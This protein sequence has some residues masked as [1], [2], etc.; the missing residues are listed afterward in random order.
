MPSKKLL[1]KEARRRAEVFKNLDKYLRIIAE[2]VKKLDPEAKAYLIGSV[3]EGR[4]LLSSDIDV[5]IVTK[6][7]PGKILSELWRAG[8]KDPFEI[9]V[10]PKNQLKKYS[11]KTK[12]FEI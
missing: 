11:E 6:L 2:V 8:I 12:L 5:L 10:T 4:H 9:H 7:P 1:V 3:A